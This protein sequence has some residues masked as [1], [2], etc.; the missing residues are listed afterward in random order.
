MNIRLLSPFETGS[1]YTALARML[2]RRPGWPEI[3]DPP[4]SA[5]LRWDQRCAQGRA[6]Y[7]EKV[8][9][10]PMRLFQVAQ[11]TLQPAAVGTHFT[12]VDQLQVNAQAETALAVLSTPPLTLR[13]ICPGSSPPQRVRSSPAGPGSTV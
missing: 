8:S 9:E 12:G 7:F 11:T 4:A 6:G 10:T 2:A 5:S 3:R 1:R 13:T